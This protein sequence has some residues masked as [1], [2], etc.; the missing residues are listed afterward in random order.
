MCID[1]EQEHI[2]IVYYINDTDGDTHIYDTDL[3]TII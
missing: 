2:S 1:R 3:T